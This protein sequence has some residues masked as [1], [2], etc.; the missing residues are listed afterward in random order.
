MGNFI[1]SPAL[2][3]EA[4]KIALKLNI[5]LLSCKI[6]KREDVALRFG[7]SPSHCVRVYTM[8]HILK[9]RSATLGRSRWVLSESC[10]S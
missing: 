5:L 3:M 2:Y 7:L 9:R 6:A 1:E 10:L 4:E 8:Y